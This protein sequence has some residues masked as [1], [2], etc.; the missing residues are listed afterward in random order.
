MMA[1][2]IQESEQFLTTRGSE[3]LMHALSALLVYIAG[4]WVIW[5]VR[6]ALRRGFEHRKFDPLVDL[7]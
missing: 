5:G 3:L 4:R 6:G 7:R 2:M 1:A